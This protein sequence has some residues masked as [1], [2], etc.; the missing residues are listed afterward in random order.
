VENDYR[1]QKM[2]SAEG[3]G[4]ARHRL[5]N[6]LHTLDEPGDLLTD[7]PLTSALLRRLDEKAHRAWVKELSELTGFWVTWHAAGGFERLEASG[8]H[9]ATIFRK[10]KRF[11]EAFGAHPDEYCFDWIGLD[12]ER[13]WQQ[14]VSPDSEM[15]V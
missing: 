2:D 7:P 3:Q 8:W 14:Q 5:A 4:L 12:L 15:D 11:R 6:F 1:S 13:L 10:V 9:R